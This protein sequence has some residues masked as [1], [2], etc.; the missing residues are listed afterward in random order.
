VYDDKFDNILGWGI[1]ISGCFE[2]GRFLKPAV[3]EAVSE[4]WND[5]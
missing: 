5:E 2:Q 1:D 4:H 3:E